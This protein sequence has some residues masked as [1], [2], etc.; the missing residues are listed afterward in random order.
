VQWG[1]RRHLAPKGV[2]F[3][4]DSEVS[5]KRYPDTSLNCIDR[6]RIV[7]LI[8][9]VFCGVALARV[10]D[11]LHVFTLLVADLQRTTVW[12]LEFDL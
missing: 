1:D 7:C 3:I 9:G 6:Q 11:V 10:H 12:R 5:P 8:H 4:P 2:F